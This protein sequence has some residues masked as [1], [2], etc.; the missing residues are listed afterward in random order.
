MEKGAWTKEHGR[1]DQFPRMGCGQLFG[2]CGG[3]ETRTSTSE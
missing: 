2:A 1:C 3:W